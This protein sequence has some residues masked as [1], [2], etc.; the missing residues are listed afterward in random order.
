ML[1]K[2][3][4]VCEL[5]ATPLKGIHFTLHRLSEKS[6]VLFIQYLPDEGRPIATSSRARPLLK[7]AVSRPNKFYPKTHEVDFGLTN[8]RLL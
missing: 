5:T 8:Q 4:D 7:T 1:S 2:I 6:F 3:I